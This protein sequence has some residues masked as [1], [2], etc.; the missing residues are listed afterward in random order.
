MANE[1]PQVC[2]S[3]PP[4]SLWSRSATGFDLG[5]D[6]R[7]PA[8]LALRP[9]RHRHEN[10]ELY[11]TKY[12]IQQRP[13]NFYL[14]SNERKTKRP[15]FTGRTMCLNSA[16]YMDNYQDRTIGCTDTI[17]STKKRHKGDSGSA[18]SRNSR[19]NEMKL[20]AA[21]LKNINNMA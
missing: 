21:A 7:R 16:N 8:T 6:P 14:D 1:N 3:P 2:R 15:I 13:R 12:T 9:D 10:S 4:A 5:A 11:P 20:G 19:E 17:C 18:I